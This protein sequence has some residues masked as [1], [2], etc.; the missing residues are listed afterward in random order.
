M[1]RPHR[2]S[3][4]LALPR[5]FYAMVDIDP[6]RAGRDVGRIAEEVL[7][8]LTTLPNANV[9]VT[10]EIESEVPEGVADDV[11]RVVNENCQTLKFKQHGFERE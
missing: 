6:D 2:V 3:L 9:K 4:A 10:V 1:M 11:Q 8:H 7:Q 5:R